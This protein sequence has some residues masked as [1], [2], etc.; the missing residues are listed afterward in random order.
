[1]FNA[2]SRRER[3]KHFEMPGS[4]APTS[5]VRVLEVE[6]LLWL[7]TGFASRDPLALAAGHANLLHLV[8]SCHSWQVN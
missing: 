4:R 8:G 1:M 5:P 3:R 6:L 2:D 7:C